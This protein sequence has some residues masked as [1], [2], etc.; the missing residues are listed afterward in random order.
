MVD[1]GGLVLLESADDALESC[2]DVG[3]VG[4]TT[5]DDQDLALRVRFST[6]DQIDCQDMRWQKILKKATH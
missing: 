4:D 2:S 5:A 3:E 1:Q 6:S